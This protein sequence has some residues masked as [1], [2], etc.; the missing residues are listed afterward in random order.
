MQSAV[1]SA[2]QPLPTL[3]SLSATHKTWSLSDESCR[4]LMLDKLVDFSSKLF[5]M[6]SSSRFTGVLWEAGMREM[7]GVKDKA[8]FKRG[9]AVVLRT[10]FLALGKVSI[11]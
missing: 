10:L 7:S 4:E 3:A 8:G 6:G 1:L 2:K 5:K 11:R 9:S